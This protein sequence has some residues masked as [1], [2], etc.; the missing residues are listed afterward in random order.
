MS[1][2]TPRPEPVQFNPSVP[3]VARMY[4]Y[5]LG[6]KNNFAADRAA[7]EQALSF[8]PELRQGAQEVRRFLR[9]AVTFLTEAGIRQFVDVGCGLPTQGNVHE[10]AQAIAPDARVAYVDN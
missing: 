9:R 1:E 5:Y 2:A 10:I 4:D 7:A 3:N 8:A 6:G